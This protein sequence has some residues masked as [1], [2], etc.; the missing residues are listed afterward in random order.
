MS[1][2]RNLSTPWPADTFNNGGFPSEQ[3]LLENDKESNS[4]YE[5]TGDVQGSPRFRNTAP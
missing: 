1:T 3:K 5:H 2:F 4:G